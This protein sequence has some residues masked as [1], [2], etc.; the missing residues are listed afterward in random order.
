VTNVN[1][2]DD[3]F[4]KQIKNKDHPQYDH[5]QRFIECLGIC[6]TV[7]SEEKV[8]KG[9][10]CKVYNASSPDELAL[11]NGMRHFG[12]AFKE[13]DIDD[14]IVIDLL[15]EGKER[16]YKLLHVIEFNSDRK[17]MSVI[18]TT[19]DGR[20]MIV[21]KGAD[22]II[23]ARLLPNQL[24]AV[25]TNRDLEQYAEVGLRTLLIAYKY[26]DEDFYK[27]WV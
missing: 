26:V 22:S 9:E 25:D 8:V 4:W 2:E 6:H 7:I 24:H 3:E 19:E 15:H 21:C 16:K 14:N 18:V 10:S 1:F 11:V 5:L 17:R 23:N 27:N 20:T 12:F 13:R